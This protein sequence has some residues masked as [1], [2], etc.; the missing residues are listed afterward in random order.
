MKKTLYITL[1]STC[2][3]LVTACSKQAWYKGAESSHDIQCLNESNSDYE[4]CINENRHSFDE[5]EDIKEQLDQEN[6]Q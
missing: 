5:Y 4:A 2:I 3:L 6:K 1:I